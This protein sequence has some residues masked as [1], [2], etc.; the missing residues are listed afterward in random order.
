[1]K[2][3]KKAFDLIRAIAILMVLI[4]HFNCVVDSTLTGGGG[5]DT[6]YLLFWN[7]NLNLGGIGVVL[8]FYV[9]RK[10]FGNDL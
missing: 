5:V 2:Q 4:F 1:M 7:T 8:F 10:P 9:V 6:N 3:K